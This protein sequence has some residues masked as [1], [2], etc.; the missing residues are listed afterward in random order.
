MANLIRQCCNCHSLHDESWT[1]RDSLGFLVCPFCGA[2]NIFTDDEKKATEEKELNEVYLLLDNTQFKSASD[3]LTILRNKYPDSSKACF[4]TVLAD[5]RV[6]FT[7]DS[8]KKGYFIPTLN[9]LPK[10]SLLESTYAKKALELAPSDLVRDSYKETFD[11]IERKRLEIQEA[12]NNKENQYDIFISTKV[13]LLENGREVLGGDGK[14]KESPDCAF[15]RDLYNDIREQYPGKKVFFSQSSDAKTK[16]AGQKYENIIYAALHSAKIFIL[17]AESRE[18]VEW[19]WVRNEWMRYLMIKDRE[20]QGKRNFV[21]VTH[22]LKEVD[23]PRELQGYNYID[24]DSISALRILKD[25][26][27]KSFSFGQERKKLEAKTFDDEVEKIELGEIE[28]TITTR[29][30]KTRVEESSEDVKAEIECYERSLDP[31]SPY[32]RAEAFRNLEE[33]LQREPD[34]YEAKKLL[35]LKDTDFHHFSDYIDNINEVIK[36]PEIASKFLEFASEE[37][38]KS[39]IESMVK[40][41][42]DETYHFGYSIEDV[43]KANNV[44]DWTKRLSTVLSSF[45]V[46]FLDS[47]NNKDL[48][49]LSEHLYGLIANYFDYETPSQEAVIN[50]YLTIRRYLDGKDP[51]L[52]IA[53]RKELLSSF[54]RCYANHLNKVVDVQNKIVSDILKINPAECE[55]IWLDFCLKKTGRP[56]KVKQFIDGIESE[57]IDVSIVGDK[58]ALNTFELLFKYSSKEERQLYTLALLTIIVHDVK[59]YEKEPGQDT[60]LLSKDA[61][62][63]DRLDDYELNGFDLF[64]KYIPYELPDIVYQSTLKDTLTNDSP[65]LSPN[66]DAYLKKERPTPL[67][68]LV[69]IFAARMHQNRFYDQA[70]NL[71][72]LYLGQQDSIKTLD[73]LLIRYYKELANVRIVLPEELRRINRQLQH[74]TINIDL[75]QLEKKNPQATVLFNKIRSA[76]EEQSEY[77]SKYQPIKDLTDQLPRE[78][79]V[80]KLP[81]IIELKDKIFNELDQVTNP[82]VRKELEKDFA[83]QLDFFKNKLPQIQ[84]ANVYISMFLDDEK[85]LRGS[86]CPDGKVDVKV[87]EEERKRILM[88]VTNYEDPALVEKRKEFINRVANDIISEQNLKEMAQKRE[89]QQKKDAAERERKSRARSAA[90]SDAFDGFINVLQVVLYLTP[91]I[92]AVVFGIILFANNKQISIV[93]GN[94]AGWTTG[95]LFY[96]IVAFILTIVFMVNRFNG[97]WDSDS[98]GAIGASVASG[99]VITI[100]MLVGFINISH[101][102]PDFDPPSQFHLTASSVSDYTDDYYYYS[103]IYFTVTNE[104]SATVTS[105]VG[106]MKLYDGGNFISSWTVTFSGEYV[107]GNTYNTSVEFKSKNSTLYNATFSNIRITYRI[108]SMQFK[109]DWQSYDFDGATMTV[110]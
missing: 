75:I 67:D 21:L 64:N 80:D 41:L 90:I 109:N 55:T 91:A 1:K 93:S 47:I 76:I 33:L 87:V 19:R 5:N 72:D 9:D 110:K 96:T 100:A 85:D 69:G 11:Y 99:I 45:I 74:R 29:K 66:T 13:T 10:Q 84:A 103:K 24:F 28:D 27:N 36:R 97:N 39:A 61:N 43:K 81:I 22:K 51:H 3:R 101:L 40:R 32:A 50:D 60:L 68:K 98:G 14:A 42:S 4:L 53:R 12:A 57:F 88:L 89:L 15:A 38:A 2:I 78:N 37:D 62:N 82:M 35:L 105:V 26:L 70:V 20:E 34:S 31:R 8:N 108:T 56:F 95:W 73:C 6:C 86:L 49:K 104:C 48:I 30:L 102:D 63:D 94:F 54:E 17:V 83:F 77:S 44:A 107:S 58:E 16:M 106:D 65:L 7:E 71:Y 92:L 25:F 52:Y 46:P 18:N 79:T 59:S 23:L